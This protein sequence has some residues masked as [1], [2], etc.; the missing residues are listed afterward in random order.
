MQQ[1]CG[2]KR[3]GKGRFDKSPQKQ[4]NYNKNRKDKLRK[5]IVNRMDGLHET[6]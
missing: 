5:T 3:E 1:R 4:Q 6:H 2:L